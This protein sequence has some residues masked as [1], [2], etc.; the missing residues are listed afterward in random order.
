MIPECLQF[1]PQVAHGRMVCGCFSWHGLGPLLVPDGRVTGETYGQLLD[2]HVYPTMLVMFDGV[3]NGILQC[4]NDPPHRSR[5]AH[6]TVE[7][8]GI[9]IRLGPTQPRFE[10][11]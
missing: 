3:E 8:L 2:E 11:H 9:E 7:A 1:K 6:A 4:D 10:P 5:T